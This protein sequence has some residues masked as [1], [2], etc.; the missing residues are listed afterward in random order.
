MVAILRSSNQNF[1]LPRSR[2]PK[3]TIPCFFKMEWTQFKFSN[4]NISA[5][6]SKSATL[7][8]GAERVST[9]F[10]EPAQCLFGPSTY[11]KDEAAD[12][13][14]VP[15]ALAQ[16]ISEFFNS[17]ELWPKG[18]IEQKS[19]RLLGKALTA[20][21]VEAA[22]NPMHQLRPQGLSFENAKLT[23]RAAPSLVDSGTRMVFKQNGHMVGTTI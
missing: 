18:Y 21:Q 23:C 1:K 16:E 6:G 8:Q 19:E 3:T 20:E 7:L 10:K 17:L 5:R 15:F 4:V 2:L 12:R 9:T 13:Q 11:E 22:Y 14:G